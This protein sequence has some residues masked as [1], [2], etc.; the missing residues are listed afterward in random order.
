MLKKMMKVMV[1]TI[2][3]TFIGTTNVCAE[4]DLMV[5]AKKEIIKELDEFVKD[6][7]DDISEE[8]LDTN[9]YKVELGSVEE[10]FDGFELETSLRVIANGDVY[11]F[12]YIFVYDYEYGEYDGD[13]IAIYSEPDNKWF[14]I[15]DEEF[16]D[17]LNARY[18]ELS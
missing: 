5:E 1:A 16:C 13:I 12:Q 18:P 4:D 7:N 3:V 17:E 14:S 9:N 11:I 6:S 8:G 10:R 2:M 15:D